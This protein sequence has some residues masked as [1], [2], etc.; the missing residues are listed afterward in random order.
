MLVTGATGALGDAVTHGLRFPSPTMPPARSQTA[1]IRSMRNK[2]TPCLS[3]RALLRSG[4]AVVGSSVIVP[5]SAQAAGTQRAAPRTPSFADLDVRSGEG[6]RR[7]RLI[8]PAGP[9][10]TRLLVLL[11]GKGET[12]SERLGLKAWSHLYGLMDA[13]ERLATP[14]VEPILERPRI[15]PERLQRLNAELK[16]R[17]FS[18]LAVV[19]PTTPN[20]SGTNDRRALFDRYTD[21]LIE[22]LVPQVRKRVPS[23]GANVG[24]D[25]CSMGG[26]VALE[27]FARTPQS[28]GSFGVVQSAIGK[29]R[30]AGYV[31]QMARLKGMDPAI[32][33][34]IQ[35]STRDPFRDASEA[36]SRELSR[37]GIPNTLDVIDGAHDQPWLRQIGTI[38]M[39]HWH[40]RHL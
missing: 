14:P 33:F 37:V 31:R 23:L 32:P 12:A 13:F 3:R 2:A 1:E 38:E 19:C 28:F 15:Q 26:Y 11:H 35:T 7:A 20:P 16:A 17:P 18:G 9:P 39:L 6:K 27:V 36:L 34:H 40:D 10:P 5:M 4:L 22:T 29:H 21:W 24:L 25:G 8:V 30:V